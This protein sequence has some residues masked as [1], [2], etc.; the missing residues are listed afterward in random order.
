[1]RNYA[2]EPNLHTR[3]Y[4]MRSRLFSLRDYTLMIREPASM[5]GN[6]SN[7]QDPTRAKESLFRQQIAPVVNLAQAFEKYT[8]FFIANLR[9]YEAQNARIL[10]T[11]AAGHQAL[12]Q[13]ND[14]GPFAALDRGLLEKK[15]SLDDVKSLLADIYLDDDFK[16]ISSYRQ[17]VIHLDI[18]TARN[19]YHSGD[20]LSGAA[21]QEFREMMLKRLAVMT[22]I[23]SYRL[24]VNHRFKD[25]RIRFYM[26]KV[27]K[28][29]GG[30][31][32]YRVSLE[33]EALAEHL[34][35]LRKDTGE[36]PSV[37]NIEHHLEQNYYAWITSVFHRDFHSIYCVVAYLWLLFYQIR[38]LFRI[39]DGRRF[40]MSQDA[41][42]NRMICEA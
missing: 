26:D 19:L 17:L 32:W 16:T 27:H 12:E 24:R 42:I 22:L 23:W 35:Q 28:L 33:K 8:P 3:I 6:I 10:L 11:R 41:I 31:V 37:A 21:V 5:P 9:Q 25:D 36:E 38:N 4:A 30:K 7:I 18:C 39:I 13:W 29:Y 14:I 2:D 15:L 1:M 40:G 20:L 34:E